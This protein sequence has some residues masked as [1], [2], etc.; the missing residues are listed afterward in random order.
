MALSMWPINITITWVLD[1]N[2]NC[3]ALKPTESETLGMRPSNVHFNKSWWFWCRQ[4]FQTQLP[5]NYQLFTPLLKIYN[6]FLTKLSCFNLLQLSFSSPLGWNN[7]NGGNHWPP[8]CQI[9]NRFLKPH[10]LIF[11]SFLHYQHHSWTPI[12]RLSGLQ[13]SVYLLSHTPFPFHIFDLKCEML[14]KKS[15]VYTLTCGNFISFLQLQPSF[16]SRL[17]QIYF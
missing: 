4:N 1:R 7:F 10:P 15:N 14:Q 17:P 6:C 11:C 5:W 13:Q 8:K 12:L 2:A 16:L 3:V 9:Q